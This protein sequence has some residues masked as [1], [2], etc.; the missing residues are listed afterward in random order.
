MASLLT[1]PSLPRRCKEHIFALIS[2]CGGNC[3][4]AFPLKRQ[5]YPGLGLPYHAMGNT[6]LG[7]YTEAMVRQVEPRHRSHKSHKSVCQ[8]KQV[9]C[10]GGPWSQA[11]QLGIGQCTVHVPS[12]LLHFP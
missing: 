2:Y 4:C 10:G 3:F 8:C 6:R 9:S 1:A 11:R 12:G 5:G 7:P